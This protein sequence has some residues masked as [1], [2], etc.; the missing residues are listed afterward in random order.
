M[1]RR[2]VRPSVRREVEEEFSHH[3]EMRV[4]DLVA[5]G[6]SEDDARRE[7]ERRFGNIEKLKADCRHVPEKVNLAKNRTDKPRTHLP[8]RAE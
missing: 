2:V 5:E 3:V 1:D 7:A 8:W 4:R 6:W